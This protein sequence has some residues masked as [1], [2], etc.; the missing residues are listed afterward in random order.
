HIPPPPTPTL[1]PSTTLFRS[2]LLHRP[3]RLDRQGLVGPDAHAYVAADVLQLIAQPVQHRP[4]PLARL[5]D[6]ALVLAQRVTQ[7]ALLVLRS[8]EH[9]SELQSRFDLVCRL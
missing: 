8:E 9:T 6:F 1:L 5:V 7:L 4:Q 2:A 3:H